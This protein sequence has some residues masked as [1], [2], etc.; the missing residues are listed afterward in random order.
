MSLNQSFEKVQ[1]MG[2]FESANISHTTIN[3]ANDRVQILLRSDTNTKGCTHW[4][5]FT[6]VA[7]KQCTVTFS[8]LN[9]KRNGQLYKD[10]MQIAVLDSL[11]SE[12]G[13]FRGG[14]NIWYYRSNV[15]HQFYQ[16]NGEN[17][18]INNNHN[19]NYNI[20]ISPNASKQNIVENENNNILPQSAYSPINANH[21]GSCINNK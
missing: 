5:M 11:Q 10:G 18:D 15:D 6:V 13:W 4:F 2:D 21:A 14:S 1:V 12:K 9:N 20:D 3:K 8:I 16:Q 19:N 17:D 7:K